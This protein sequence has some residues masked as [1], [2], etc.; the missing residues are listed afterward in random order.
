M[1]CEKTCAGY[2]EFG[3][4]KEGILIT[5]TPLSQTQN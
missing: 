4:A 1:E 2:N 5:T 3:D